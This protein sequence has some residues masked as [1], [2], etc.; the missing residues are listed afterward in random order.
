MSILAEFGA[1]AAFLLMNG[2]RLDKFLEELTCKV[3]HLL[4]L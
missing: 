1:I 2:D 3:A 4:L